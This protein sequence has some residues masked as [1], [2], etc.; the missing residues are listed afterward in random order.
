MSQIHEWK[1]WGIQSNVAGPEDNS[2]F[3]LLSI[4]FIV[5]A[6]SSHTGQDEKHRCVKKLK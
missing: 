1:Q 6:L 5:A 2:V 4:Y 3:Q